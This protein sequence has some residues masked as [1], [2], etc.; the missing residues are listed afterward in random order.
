MQRLLGLLERRSV[1]LPDLHRFEGEQDAE[2]RIDLEVDEGSRGQ[3][4]GPGDPGLPLGSVRLVAS[5]LPLNEGEQRE[6]D[7]DGQPRGEGAD[8]GPL[9]PGG[10]L[11][12][13]QQVLGVQGG[14]GGLPAAPGLGELVF[15][16]R[17]T[18]E[19]ALEVKIVRVQVL[20]HFVVQISAQP[21]RCLRL[22]RFP[23]QLT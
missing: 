5:L 14:G 11:A 23:S 4:S 3:L 20:V 15:K 6:D 7:G 18:V 19:Y 16:A 10:R 1:R 9:A 22:L 2:L 12:A 8:P 21:L 17:V 13:C